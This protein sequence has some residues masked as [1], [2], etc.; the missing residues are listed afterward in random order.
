[1][2]A[3]IRDRLAATFGDANVFMDV[4]HLLPGQRFDKELEKALAQTDV[5]LAVIGPRWTELL[6][7]RQDSR[8]RDYVREEIAGALQRGVVVIPVLIERTPLPRANALPEDIRDLVLHQTHEVA[9]NGFGRDVAGLVE[10]IRLV[11]RAART[12]ADGNSGSAVRWLGAAALAALLSG[13]GWLVYPWTVVSPEQAAKQQEDQAAK[14]K[15]AKKK[16]DDEAEQRRLALLKAEQDRAA[17]DARKR[18]EAKRKADE[19]AARRDPALS[20]T[21]GSGVSFRDRLANGQACPSCPEMVVV[22]A[23]GFM[24]G[25][26]PDEAD[27]LSSE[28]PQRRVTIPR[29]FAV[30]KFE[31]TF[32]EWAACVAEGRCQD[33]YTDQNRRPLIHVSW[34]DAKEYAAWLSDKTGKEYRLLREA[35]WEYAARAGTTTRY[36]FGY[37][38][39]KSQ[40]QYGADKTAEVGTFP[41][42]RWGLYDVHGNVWEWVEDAWHPNY[43]GAPNDGSEWREGD[44]ALRVLRGGSWYDN[45]P[46]YL[47]SAVR[48]KQRPAYRNDNVGF[49]LARTLPP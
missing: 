13:A 40:A 47:R 21:P 14:A 32:V 28:G 5:F 38:I 25:S 34:R 46:D 41:P 49:R 4:D 7:E 31:V 37:T 18:A 45:G 22:P 43:Q 36:A 12:G 6:A 20:V 11:R 9:H 2:A 44:A 42:N 16:A 17:A 24:M 33:R 39:S 10:A 30:G 15:A 1:M 8:E 3:R 35:E 19:E 23:G 26:P 27:R 48:N 29:P